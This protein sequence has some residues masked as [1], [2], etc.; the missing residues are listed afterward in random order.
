[1]RCRAFVRANINS[2]ISPVL[3]GS[4]GGAAAY[5]LGNTSSRTI[6]ELEQG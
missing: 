2:T 1:M 4:Y 5:R 3:E 6:T